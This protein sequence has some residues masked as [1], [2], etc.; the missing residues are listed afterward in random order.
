MASIF[1]TKPVD[2]DAIKP[3]DALQAIY[4]DWWDN[5]LS[6]E[7]FAEYYGLSGQAAQEL[8]QVARRVHNDRTNNRSV[9]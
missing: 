5:F 4:L 8:I 7:R 2:V 1:D 9:A 6:V 3:G